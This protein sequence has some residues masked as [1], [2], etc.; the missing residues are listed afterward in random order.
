MSEIYDV[1]IVE[2]GPGGSITAYYLAKEG[3]NT[4]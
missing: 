1:V 4:A 2:A 3:S